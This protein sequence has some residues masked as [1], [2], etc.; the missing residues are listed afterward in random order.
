MADNIFQMLE[1]IDQ[2]GM[3]YDDLSDDQSNSKKY[4]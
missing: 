2:I 3:Q 1:N 4:L